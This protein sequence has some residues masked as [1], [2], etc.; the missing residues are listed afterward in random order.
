MGQALPRPVAHDRPQLGRDATFAG[1]RYRSSGLSDDDYWLKAR[2]PVARRVTTG[3]PAQRRLGPRPLPKSARTD[4]ASRS[5]RR[6]PRSYIGSEAVGQSPTRV[7]SARPAFGKLGA[8][9]V[10]LT[11]WRGVKKRGDERP[12][13]DA[14]MRRAS[15]LLET[16]TLLIQR[17]IEPWH[18]PQLEAAPTVRIAPERQLPA[19][20]QPKRPVLSIRT[21]SHQTPHGATGQTEAV[22]PPTPPRLVPASQPIPIEVPSDLELPSLRG[23]PSPSVDGQA[24]PA[25]NFRR[26]PDAMRSRLNLP[27]S[28]TLTRPP[29]GTGA[30][31]SPSLLLATPPR[32]D[33]RTKAEYALEDQAA[34][35]ETPTMHVHNRD[36]DD[37][38]KA[39]GSGLTAEAREAIATASEARAVKDEL[40]A[41]DR[42][43]LG[44]TTPDIHIIPATGENTPV[45][46]GKAAEMAAER[47]E[48][49]ASPLDAGFFGPLPGDD[50]E[51]CESIISYVPTPPAPVIAPVRVERPPTVRSVSSPISAATSRDERRSTFGVPIAPP[52]RVVSPPRSPPAGPPPRRPLPSAPNGRAS[53][54]PVP[55]TPPPT[56]AALGVRQRGL[57]SPYR[58]VVP[59]RPAA[60]VTPPASRFEEHPLAKYPTDAE[61]A[62]RSSS[63]GGTI[64]AF[65]L[66]AHF[67]P[68]PS[69]RDHDSAKLQQHGIIARSDL[70]AKAE[71]LREEKPEIVVPP[72]PP[73]VQGRQRSLR[74]RLVRPSQPLRSSHVRAAMRAHY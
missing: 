44:S 10:R 68:P 15:V 14:P 40:L 42:S 62:A 59:P 74:P 22:R 9:V 8:S 52:S 28:L 45:D 23:S 43:A 20:P 47:A 53:Q 26:T 56:P 69:S 58:P 48:M 24:L 50:D 6:R 37:E 41:R 5:T 61:V 30:D 31:G 49:V 2:E 39:S 67:P 12:V 33:T 46:A 38:P 55:P 51:E 36:D 29:F 60:L 57:R 64:K 32:H 71:Y 27:S 70:V 34:L 13:L 7:R 63:S 25:L 1:P 18:P 11:R 16:A 21:Q 3:S 54:P 35:D 4:Q 65:D 72:P 17:P 73:Y 66:Y 19:T